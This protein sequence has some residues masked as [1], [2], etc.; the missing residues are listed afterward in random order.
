RVGDKGQAG[1]FYAADLIDRLKA[2][3]FPNG[4]N[5]T[6]ETP[7]TSETSVSMGKQ[8]LTTYLKPEVTEVNSTAKEQP[9]NSQ[10]PSKTVVSEVSEQTEVKTETPLCCECKKETVFSHEDD[11]KTK[12]YKCP[13]GHY[14]AEKKKL[15]H[16]FFDQEGTENSYAQLTC[17][18]CGKGIMDNDWEQSSF[19]EN[20]P[21]H[22]KCCDEKRSQL[23]SP[24]EMPDFEDKCQPPEEAS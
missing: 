11:A 8:S 10:L 13:S 20:K 2:R 15:P 1:F 9:K 4:S 23:K 3:Y 22:K 5:S 16:G 24:V 12:W 7:E 6:S 17:Y 19:S 18:F 14:T 21:A